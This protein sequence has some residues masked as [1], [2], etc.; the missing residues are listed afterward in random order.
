MINPIQNNHFVARSAPPVFNEGAAST[1]S[2][3]A[4]FATAAITALA[5]FVF[6]PAE[7][8]LAVSIG[9]AA[10]LSLLC[11]IPNEPSLEDQ[12]RRWYHPVVDAFRVFVPRGAVPVVNAGPRVPVGGVMHQH[13]E[14]IVVPQ[15]RQRVDHQEG[16]RAPVGRGHRAPA[17]GVAVM[18]QAWAQ[19][20][21][22]HPVVDHAP[23]AAGPAAGPAP[24]RVPVGHPNR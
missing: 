6:L 24:R 4:A 9:A 14:P 23:P 2:K 12:P 11:C 15:Q 19:Q 13:V 18:P 17:G 16:P 3:I 7:A 10:L 8:A 5:S 21:A 20:P 1:A 22:V